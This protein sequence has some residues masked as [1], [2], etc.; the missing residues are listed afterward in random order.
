MNKLILIIE[1]GDG[2][3]WGRIEDK[4]NFLPVTVA[5]SIE[6]VISS[7]RKLIQDYLEHEGKNDKFW[8][9]IDPEK[10]IFEIRYDLQ[11]FFEEHDELRISGLAKK[12]GINESLLKQFAIGKKHPSSEQVE[13]LENAIHDLARRLQEVSIC[14]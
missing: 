14:P 3:W 9:K 5:N 8:S 13:K 1:K 12:S 2:E 11:A 7:M 4:G 6:E 10:A